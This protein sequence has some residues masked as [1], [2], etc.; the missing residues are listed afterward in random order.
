MHCLGT[1]NVHGN[2]PDLQKQYLELLTPPR[3]S[4]MS[5]RYFLQRGND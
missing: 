4:M 2:L 1:N 3:Q 5:T